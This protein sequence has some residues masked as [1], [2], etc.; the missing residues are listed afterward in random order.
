[1][2]DKNFEKLELNKIL[3]VAAEYA[4]TDG[5][6]QN[7]LK[8][9]PSVTL[10]DVR[11]RLKATEECDRLLFTYGAGKVEAFPP[12]DDPISRAAKG[13]ALSCGEL[14]DVCALM[15]A[16]RN[17]YESVY[18]VDDE[19]IALVR[20]LVQNLYF[21]ENAE[22]DITEKVISREA[23][24]DRAS[25][26]LYDIRSR[27]KLLNERIRARLAEY[28][29]GKDG[30]FLQGGIA[31]IRNDRYV[32]PVKAEHKSR[33]RGF[34]HDRSKT[35]ATFFIEPE[36]ILELN[37][38]LIALQ[39]DEREE[40]EAILR[41]LSKRI[42][43]V[44]DEL[45]ADEG[46][47]YEIDALF[48]KAE[49]S[50]SLR[51]INPKTNNRG[52]IDIVKGRHPLIPKDKV[53]P[54]SVSL[55]ADYNFL[56]LSGANTGGKTVTLKMTGLFC[57]MAACGIF[58]PAAEG[59][60]VAVFSRVFCDIG[61]S[62]SIE[63]SLSTFSSHLTNVIGICN[64]ADRDSLIL[65]DELG[66]GTNPDEGQAIAKAVVKHFLSL[67]ARGIVTTHFTPLKEYAY[68]VGGIENAS[69]EFDSKTLK[70]LY[71]M[72][73]GLPGTSNALAISRRLGMDKGILAD[74]ESFLSEGARNFENVLQRAEKSRVEAEEKL[75]AAEE[76]RKS[77]EQKLSEVNSKIDELN[78]EKEKINRSARVE[79][80]RI[81]ADRTEKAEEMLAEMEEIFEKQERDM[82]DLVKARTLKNRLS[83]IA[84][85]DGDE[86]KKVTEFVAA[87]EKNI[88]AGQSVY[89]KPMDCRGEVLQFNQKKGE[90]EVLCG[91]LRMHIKLS[92]LQIVPKAAES[93]TK[94]TKIYKNI[95]REKPLL[96]INVLGMTV[97]EA[98]YETDNFIDRAVLDNLEE[99]K[100]IH[101]VGT[102]K[103]K[104]AIR[105]RLARHKNVE[106]FRSG[107]YG[108]GEE[109]VTIVR[110]K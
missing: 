16:A 110:L 103:L 64:E 18:K 93:G 46:V 76:M 98:V 107:K 78:R 36:Y 54:V 48:A 73:I 10:S 24:S 30:E 44:A 15:R 88:A 66:G 7:L 13:A 104:T 29:A 12:C 6:R 75:A 4:S 32:I 19:N 71:S 22:R 26:K 70:P 23:L 5:G 100:I 63:E 41:T 90:A 74:A 95:P 25:D 87:T 89:V 38:E 57:L 20:K 35:G 65:I 106:S 62:Q 51:G 2:N 96:E 91:S 37:N 31:T 94:K 84:F 67:G 43:A 56:L 108:E 59:S 42:G 58:I 47:L 27:I 49:Y 83:D 99:I 40:I 69:M 21:D 77:W 3:A 105:E 60:E 8:C 61:D 39:I 9:E 14:L 33:V 85:D 101:G 86:K 50:Y 97:P 17:I 79:S 53:V 82:R 109:G 1:M 45:I 28:A 102:G 55:G 52:Y 34:V 72:K 81:I 80:R 92:D 11:D 68:S